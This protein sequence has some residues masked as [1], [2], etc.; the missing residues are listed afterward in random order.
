MLDSRKPV[1]SL[2][3]FFLCSIAK[4]YVPYIYMINLKVAL[5]EDIT[6]GITAAQKA[7]DLSLKEDLKKVVVNHPDKEG[8]GDYAS[9]IALSLT[10][11]VGKPPM[12]IVEI[13][14]QYMPK[15][16]YI[17][18]I[19]AAAPGF[20]NIWISHDW[21]IARLDDVTEQDLCGDISVG[22]G[23][24]VNLEFISANPTGPLTL[25]NARTAFSV[26]TLANVFECAGFNVIREYYFNDAGAQIKRLGESVVR[27]IL[28][29]QGE[30]VEFPE[31]LYQGEYIKEVGKTVAEYWKENE[32]KTF[33]AADLENPELMDK[34]SKYAVEILLNAIKKT[35]TDDLKIEFDVW[36][37]EQQIRESGV[38][39]ESLNKLKDI[40][41][42]YEKDGA[43]WFKT[44]DYGEEKDKVLVKQ[45]GEYA[46]ITPD[47]GYHQAKYNRGFD[48]IF[49]FV[50]ADH[51]G[52]ITKLKAAMDALGNDVDKLH[53]VV[54]QWMRLV[55]SGKPVKFSKRR[56]NVFGP[57]DLIDEI[58]YDAARFFMTQHALTTHMD[59][60]LD[61]AKER[62]ERNPVYYVQYAYVRLQSIIRK[63][64]EQG[65]IETTGDIPEYEGSII[66][67]DPV[68]YELIRTMYQFPEVVRDIA[69]SYEVHRLTYFASDLAKAVH[70]FYKKAPVL[71]VAD[72]SLA[73]GRLRLVLAA[74][75][76]LEQTLDLM[77]ISKPDVM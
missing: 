14:A 6:E 1:H 21:L 17:G 75:N 41:K 25:G 65:L 55:K 67:A 12:E 69:E 64:K 62:S 37:S 16:E 18:K 77:G 26:D 5:A 40:G 68:E 46:Y 70:V 36:T 2:C 53:F 66:L 52:Q 45:D 51:Q 44:T 56:G 30:N 22:A 11:Q 34:V 48:L 3:G 58:G 9:P 72:I 33:T 61:I 23:R 31:E 4:N 71:N 47:I 74:R 60:D 35:I 19:E 73:Q 76:V 20:L 29:E 8:L 43:L 57:K 54:S 39:D 13:I 24:M 59:L 50:G 49:T 32:G 27:R 10:K 28:Q 7:G 38:I 15:K 42:T 63:A